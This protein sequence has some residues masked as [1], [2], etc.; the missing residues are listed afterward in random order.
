MINRQ[1]T[2]NR[3][4]TLLRDFDA[5]P[6]SKHAIYMRERHDR[7]EIDD[8]TYAVHSPLDFAGE[9]Y[10]QRTILMIEDW[11]D[12]GCRDK[13]LGEWMTLWARVMFSFSEVGLDVDD[14]LST[15]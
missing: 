11:L 1:L 5:N 8:D 4:L 12:R 13:Y 9:Y 3:Y 14:F 15:D 7:G 6:P 2:A 10:V